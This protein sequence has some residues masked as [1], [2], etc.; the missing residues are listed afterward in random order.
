[1]HESLTHPEAAQLLESLVASGGGLLS[2]G[3]G[4]PGREI[5]AVAGAQLAADAGTSLTI[6]DFRHLLPQLRSVVEEAHPNLVCAYV[7]VS[8]AEDQLPSPDGVLVVHT[9]LLRVPRTRTALLAMAGAAGKLVVAAREEFDASVLDGLSLPRF[10]FRHRGQRPSTPQE[11]T[12]CP[13]RVHQPAQAAG[14]ELQVRWKTSQSGDVPTHLTDFVARWSA[15]PAAERA[16]RL[17]RQGG[18]QAHPGRI[19][20]VT[21]S[22]PPRPR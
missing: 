9:D 18:P 11:P 12:Q 13:G 2:Y 8:E 1:M 19:R 4:A 3:L 17:L 6:V 14:L 7:P 21:R 22:W 20:S 10:P 5:A 16:Q 15:P